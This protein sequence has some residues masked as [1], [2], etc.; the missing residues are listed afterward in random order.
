MFHEKDGFK[1]LDVA[2]VQDK[3]KLRKSRYLG[4]HHRVLVLLHWQRRG[5]PLRQPESV[6]TQYVLINSRA[7][8]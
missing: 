3:A 1:T 7:I 2:C 6:G 4:F 5:Q 8:T